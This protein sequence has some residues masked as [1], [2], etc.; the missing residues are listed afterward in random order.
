[1]ESSILVGR[2]VAQ[3]LLR[4]EL[5]DGHTIALVKFDDGSSGIEFDDRLI[6]GLR[7]HSEKTEECVDVFEHFVFMHGGIRGPSN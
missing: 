4:V 1:M 5:Q 6:R 2:R 7:W 3:R